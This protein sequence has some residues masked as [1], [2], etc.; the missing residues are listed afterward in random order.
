MREKKKARKNQKLFF[1]F[2][3]LGD[4]YRT[5]IFLLLFFSLKKNNNNKTLSCVSELLVDWALARC[6]WAEADSS[7][8][9]PEP[10]DL[11]PQRPPRPGIS[12]ISPE[13]RRA[14]CASRLSPPQLSSPPPTFHS[15]GLRPSPTLRTARPRWV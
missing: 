8:P 15:R 1:F 12:N 11:Q 3:S 4:N 14:E 5:H 6:A 13:R 10:R 2:F 7:A 9:L